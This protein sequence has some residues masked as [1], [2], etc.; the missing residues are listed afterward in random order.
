[1]EYFERI[2]KKLN[3]SF[4]PDQLEVIDESDQHAGH[5]GAR[6]EGETHFKVRMVSKS[7]IGK[8]RLQSQR[9]VYRVLKVELEERIHALSLELSAPKR[10]N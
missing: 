6:P 1:M 3:E 9:E 8:S 2:K 5:V 7:F 10:D 4:L